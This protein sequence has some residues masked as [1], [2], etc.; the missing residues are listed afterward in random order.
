MGLTRLLEAEGADDARL[1]ASSVYKQGGVPTWAHYQPSCAPLP[2]ARWTDRHRM[3]ERIPSAP[4]GG[5]GVPLL[6]A[7]PTLM[8]DTSTGPAGPHLRADAPLPDLY[9]SGDR[10]VRRTDGQSDSAD[11]ITAAGLPC[12]QRPTGVFSPLCTVRAGPCC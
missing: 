1:P 10:W 12:S 2:A 9:A 4:R 5:G 11:F 3:T 7:P 6:S 8:S